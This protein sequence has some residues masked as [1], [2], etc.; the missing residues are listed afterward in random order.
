MSDKTEKLKIKIFS[1][2]ESNLDVTWVYVGLLDF[3]LKLKPQNMTFHQIWANTSN[4]FVICL[5]FAASSIIRVW[6]YDK[7]P[8]SIRFDPESNTYI[9][10][11]YD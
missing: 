7:F 3:V 4:L 9:L 11:E 1:L 8:Q 5:R 6:T 2:K 10:G